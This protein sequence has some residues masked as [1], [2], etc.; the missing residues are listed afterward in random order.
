MAY[1]FNLAQ[2]VECEVQRVAL[3]QIDKALAEIDDEQL[4]RQEVVHQVRKRCKKLRGLLR[5]VRVAL[6]DPDLYTFE[7][8]Y[9]RDAARDLSGVRDAEVLIKTC[10]KLMETSAGDRER[11]AFRD[12]QR[13]LVFQREQLDPE[14]PA[15][16]SKLATFR[17]RMLEARQRIGCWRL[18]VEGPEAAK[19]GLKRTY[20]RGRRAIRKAYDTPSG[21]NFHEWR[22]RVK[23]HWYHGRLL[24]EAWEPVLKP[25]IGELDR[26]ASQ[27]GDYHD[28]D[29]LRQRIGRMPPQ[30]VSPETACRLRELIQAR[31]KDI[32][33]EMLPLGQRV[34]AEKP[35]HLTRRL[36]IYCRVTQRAVDPA[37]KEPSRAT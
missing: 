36:L 27:L 10:D 11:D 13:E 32:R 22:K 19:A 30:V 1:R 33:A 34:F 7:N 28:L 17:D 5:L 24:R 15:V 35:K 29:V 37:A 26:L 20:R 25:W 23:Y 4:D 6:D 21:E 8:G 16:A 14:G 2:P 3:E 18:C 12:A 31:Q 9:F